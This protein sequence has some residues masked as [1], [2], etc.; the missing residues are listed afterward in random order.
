M[1]HTNDTRP[2]EPDI[3]VETIATEGSS[4]IHVWSH[5][6]VWTGKAQYQGGVEFKLAGDHGAS[7]R[8]PWLSK[9]LITS[10]IRNPPTTNYKNSS[11][12]GVPS[13]SVS[14]EDQS[15]PSETL[16]DKPTKGCIETQSGRVK[17]RSTVVPQSSLTVPES[18]ADAGLAVGSPAR[19]DVVTV[20]EG[21][22]LPTAAAPIDGAPE[23]LPNSRR[24]RGREAGDVGENG[25]SAKKVRG[26]DVQNDTRPHDI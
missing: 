12:N 9:G 24:K 26:P 23:S 20:A 3:F 11:R 4:S 7:F 16:D 6:A 21:L 1:S 19:E 2:D 5:P 10:E 15:C 13:T 18:P 14:K 8:L 17:P 25:K 22:I